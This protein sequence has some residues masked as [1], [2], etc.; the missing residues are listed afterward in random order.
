MNVVI[1][2]KMRDRLILNGVEESKIKV[3]HNWF[4]GELNHNV[5]NEVSEL[6]KD[7]GLDNKFVVGYS[8]NLGRA[9]DHTLF[10]KTV[11]LLKSKENILFLFIG[12]G[13]G[14]DELKKGAI[15]KNLKNIKFKPY[16]PQVQLPV[17]LSI[18][19]IHLISLLPSLE[20]L[21]VPSKLY[22]VLAVKR[23][24]LFI[25]SDSGEIS[26]I[27]NTYNLGCVV[28]DF[29]PNI[30]AKQIINLLLNGTN[31]ID[32][33]MMKEAECKFSFKIAFDSWRKLFS[34]ISRP[35]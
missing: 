35:V 6:K 11:E 25:G 17:T 12:G 31:F 3:I 4:V 13:Y 2:E 9:H 24:V 22:G 7:W 28:S 21:I 8:G 32:H 33:K 19:D 5:E 23:P 1:G 10:L 16:Q 15:D 34:D 18:P 26:K 14:M 29:N 27:V 30:L 20:G